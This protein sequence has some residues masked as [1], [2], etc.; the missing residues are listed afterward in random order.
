MRT[1]P[2][3]FSPPFPQEARDKEGGVFPPLYIPLKFQLKVSRT[4]LMGLNFQP[5]SARRATI[6]LRGGGALTKT[7]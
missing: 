7:Q 6:A 1:F 2:R 5:L 3:F 4:Q